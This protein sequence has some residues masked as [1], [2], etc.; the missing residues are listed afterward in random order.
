MG[1]CHVIQMR[2][3]KWPATTNLNTK[4]KKEGN[5]LRWSTQSSPSA[6]FNSN[7]NVKRPLTTTAQSQADFATSVQR[8]QRAGGRPNTLA[9]EEPR[10][11][12]CHTFIQVIPSIL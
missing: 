12:I 5:M 9:S 3:P 1:Q 11:H 4:T 10:P 7:I 2:L 6:A 8:L